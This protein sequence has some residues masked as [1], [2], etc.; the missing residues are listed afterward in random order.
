[1]PFPSV[2]RFS[3]YP[4]EILFSKFKGFLNVAL[5]NWRKA[6]SALRYFPYFLPCYCIYAEVAALIEFVTK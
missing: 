3:L 5:Y 1:M 6:R 4:L 2:R